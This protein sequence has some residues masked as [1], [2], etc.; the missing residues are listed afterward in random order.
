[1]VSVSGNS[2]P[3]PKYKTPANRT[4]NRKN[5]KKTRKVTMDAKAARRVSWAEHGTSKMRISAMRLRLLE[6]V[7][8]V[9]AAKAQVVQPSPINP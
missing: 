1:M 7:N 9:S 5:T 6:S 3:S 8:G 2:I 4:K